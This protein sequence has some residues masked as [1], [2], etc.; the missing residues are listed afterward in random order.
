MDSSVEV[1]SDCSDVS[2]L[3]AIYVFD[4]DDSGDSFILIDS[5]SESSEV[6]GLSGLRSETS[7]ILPTTS[8]NHGSLEN[9]SQTETAIENQAP[10]KITEREKGSLM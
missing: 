10:D 8:N 1:E 7:E 5:D 3:S 2:D 9:A 6:A 4:S